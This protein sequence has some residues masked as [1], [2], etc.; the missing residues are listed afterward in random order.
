[1]QVNDLL[2]HI[3]V[4]MQFEGEW[5]GAGNRRVCILHRKINSN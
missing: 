2:V 5:D 1:M 4:Y 3:S